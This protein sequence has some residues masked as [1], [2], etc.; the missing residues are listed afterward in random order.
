MLTGLPK[1]NLLLFISAFILLWVAFFIR[2]L[3]KDRMDVDPKIYYPY[4]GYSIFIVLWILTNFYFQ[5][6]LLLLYDEK[7]A[8]FMAIFAN[9][10]SY[11]AFAFA[12]LFSCRLTSPCKNKEIKSWQIVLFYAES[13]FALAINLTPNFTVTG[14]TIVDKGVF[15]IHF[16]PYASIFFINAFLFI[17]L[18]IHN[19]LKL[20]KSKLK[21]NKEKSTYLLF[22]ILIF[23][24]STIISQIIIPM[25]W[26]DFSF[27]WVPPVLSVTE[28]V[29]IGYTLLYHRL[30]S[31]RYILYWTLSYCINVSLFLLPIII[32]FTNSNTDSLLLTSIVIIVFTGLLWDK[33]LKVTKLLSCVLIYKAKKTP[34]QKI[35]DIADEFK[36]STQNAMAQLASLLDTPQEQFLLVGNNTNYNIFIPHF[37]QSNSALVKDE[38]DYQIHYA[39][40]LNQS[41]LHEIQKEMDSKNTALILPIFGENRLISHLLIAPDKRN[42]S[43]F[44]NEEITAIQWVLTRVQGYI[45]NEKKMLQSQALASSIAHEMR[46][47]LAQL[48]Y[49]FE[50][51]GNHSNYDSKEALSRISKELEQGKLAIQRGAQLI[52]IILSESK[53]TKINPDIFSHYSIAQLIERFIKEYA[54]DTNQYY[55]RIQLDLSHNYAIKVNDTLFGFIIFNLIR[56]A[57]YYFDDYD[58]HISIKIQKGKTFNQLIFRDNGP[59]IDSH[60]L[61]NIF[62]DFFTHNKKG[63]SGLGLSYC[64]RVMQAFGGKIACYSQKGNFTEF[65]LSF[66]VIDIDVASLTQE[67]EPLTSTI[68]KENQP[69]TVL[70]VDDKKLQRMLIQT[71][72]AQENL[73]ILHAEN[74]KEAIDIIKEKQVDL[75]FMDSRM[76]VMNGMEAAK[77]I[78]QLHPKLPIIALT[79][80]SSSYGTVQ[81]NA[82]IDGCLTK[83]V[84]KTQLLQALNKSIVNKDLQQHKE[85]KI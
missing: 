58:S 79:G 9:L 75:I 3:F 25:I 59:G 19:F 56:N 83:P 40:E 4:I 69:K 49:H 45:E 1:D 39:P 28:A 81:S 52:D 46:N 23:M 42:G 71:Y 41:D 8:V 61:P 21:L 57:S 73:H 44:S 63:G 76:P 33:T 85:V 2:S 22:G 84:S 48:Q 12:F 55:Q 32:I 82:I 11:F 74:G 64:L 62:D 80:E 67:K 37:N 68:T 78:K 50:Q 20:R 14:V 30:Y 34:V 6:E 5:S 43:T 36:Y 38:L 47:P 15:T 65:V 53:K 29:L 66:P 10:A 31:I 16:G 35:Y 17:G 7:T 51:I 18:I 77:I 27:A 60:I 54:F 26:H 24:S 70:I 13:L 72:L